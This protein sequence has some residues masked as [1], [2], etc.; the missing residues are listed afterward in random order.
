V[1]YDKNEN[2][3]CQKPEKCEVYTVNNNLDVSRTNRLWKNRYLFLLLLPVIAYYILFKYIPMYGIMISFENYNMFKGVFGSPWIGLE[4]FQRI[5]ASTDFY[6]VLRNTIVLNLLQ[7]F[8]GF[9]FP[10]ALA[11]L[12]NE[13]RNSAFKR[14]TQ[15]LL[16]LPHFMSW[17]V[18]ASLII[19]ILSPNTG[20]VNA[21]IRKMGFE[22]V[23]F[24]SENIWWIAVYVLAGIWK[25]AGW[26]TIIY[27]AALTGVDPQL[28]DAAVVDG[29]GRWKQTLHVTLPSIRPT[30]TVMLILSMGRVMRIPFDQPFLMG[31]NSVLEVSDVISTYV[32]RVGI[33]SNDVSRATAIGLF[34][35]VICFVMLMLSNSISKKVSDES[36]Y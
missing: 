32:Y 16:Y 31:N 35:S 11:L 33:I 1:Q 17:V 24:L 30:I 28:Y 29:A 23:Y 14:T 9:P 36:I 10:V 19:A 25:N 15:A 34:Q 6:K 26:D 4:N 3:P 13:V 20:I 2:R 12:L 18:A 7:L 21:V 8:I 22:P 5:F 27:L